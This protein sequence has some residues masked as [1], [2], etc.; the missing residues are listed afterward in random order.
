M[1]TKAREATL[2]YA[3]DL[4]GKCGEKPP[5]SNHNFITQWYGIDGPWCDM[6]VS[7][8]F[9]K[10]DQEE[11]GKHAYT[12]EHAESFKE[13]KRL[14]TPVNIERGDLAFFDFPDSVQRIQHVGFVLKRV[15]TTLIQTMEFNTS[16]GLSGSQDDGGNAYIRTRALSLVV[17]GGRPAYNGNVDKPVFDFPAKAWFGLGDGGADIKMWKIDLRRWAAD[18]KNPKFDTKEFRERLKQPANH[19]DEDTVKATK[20]FQ[21]VYDLDVDGRVGKRTIRV[22]DRVRKRQEEK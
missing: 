22:M 8:V 12:P 10:T 16:S 17:C 6:G 1:E 9:D 4:R 13:R 7:Y 15:S 20:T 11:E 21:N 18:L 2:Q 3:V 19:F 5:G 14:I